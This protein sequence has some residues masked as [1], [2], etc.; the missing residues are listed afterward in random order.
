MAF[1]SRKEAERNIAFRGLEGLPSRLERVVKRAGKRNHFSTEV[2]LAFR[3]QAPYIF[4][5]VC[6][7]ME[8]VPS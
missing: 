1:L 6:A 2:S 5:N 8:D 4:L 3:N 7:D